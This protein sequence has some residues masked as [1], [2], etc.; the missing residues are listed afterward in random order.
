MLSHT[1]TAWC[2][3]PRC[4][5]APRARCSRA[6]HRAILPAHQIAW[7]DTDYLLARSARKATCWLFCLTFDLLVLIPTSKVRFFSL[8]P[9]MKS[10]VAFLRAGNLRACIHLSRRV[11]ARRP[12]SL[13]S[14]L[15]RPHKI[16]TTIKE[17]TPPCACR[18]APHA[19]PRP[20]QRRTTP[21]LNAPRSSPHRD[22]RLTA[23]R[24]P[25][26]HRASCAV[27]KVHRH[28][29]LRRH[30]APAARSPC[31]PHHPPAPPHHRPP[32]H[33]T[34]RPCLHAIARPRTVRLPT[35]VT[36]SDPVPLVHLQPPPRLQQL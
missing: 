35:V 27:V 3:L 6:A 29:P 7:R 24:P 4:A 33:R 28:R 17:A 14:L 2:Y 20:L 31:R 13:P 16:P 19:R 21:P 9:T 23:L 30:L 34:I 22:R 15:H 25:S 12:P 5:I 36:S 11:N 8:R 26:C 1:V 10:T 18:R 32:L